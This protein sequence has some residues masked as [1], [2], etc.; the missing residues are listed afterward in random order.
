MMKA[1]K[2]RTNFDRVREFNT[3]Y[4]QIVD[5]PELDP[6]TVSLRL[7][8]IDE[9]CKEVIEA[10]QKGD[11]LEIAKELTDLL[12]VVYGVGVTFGIDLDACFEE[13]HNSN[14]S[15][16]GIDGKPIYREDGK[17]LKGPNYRPADLTGIVSDGPTGRDTK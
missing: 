10:F 13:V 2:H 15:K 5:N 11:R 3:V 14:M 6:A 17:I 8:L 9:E 4:G 12:Y 16:L 1:H 7:K